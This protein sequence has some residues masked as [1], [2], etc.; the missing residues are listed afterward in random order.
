MVAVGI[1]LDGLEGRQVRL[2]YSFG[3]LFQ[4]CYYYPSTF[5]G[6]GQGNGASNTA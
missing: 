6:I 2:G 1:L 4:V 5:A 3:A